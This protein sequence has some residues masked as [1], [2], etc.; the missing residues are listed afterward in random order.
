M[1][2]RGPWTDSDFESLNWHDVPVYGFHFESFSDDEGTSDVVFDID[3]I[4]DWIKARDSLK[5]SMCRAELRFLGVF[6]F[7]A[8]LDYAT[9]TAGMCPFSIHEIVRETPS[10]V[11]TNVLSSWKIA[12]NWPPGEI[13]F[14]A[15]GFRQKL[16]GEP[17]L[18]GEQRLDRRMG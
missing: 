15:T 6:G 11:A 9:P 3:Y 2:T 13:S 10:N 18:R 8:N 12:I 17:Q 1:K 4:L 7:Q 14:Q 16:V 5:F